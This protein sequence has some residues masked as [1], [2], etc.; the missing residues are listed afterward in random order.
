MTE[1][2]P[3]DPKKEVVCKRNP[4]VGDHPFVDQDKPNFEG[5]VVLILKRKKNP[6]KIVFYSAKKKFRNYGPTRGNF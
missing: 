5:R 3:K 6:L 4:A 2:G 1:L